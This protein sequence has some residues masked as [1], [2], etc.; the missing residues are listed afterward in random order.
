[1]KFDQKFSSPN[2]LD[3]I[4]SPPIVGQSAYALPPSLPA[5]SAPSITCTKIS[6]INANGAHRHAPACDFRG[7]H[8]NAPSAV[9][10]ASARMKNAIAR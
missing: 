1:V 7:G 4:H 10:S 6:V 2:A 9:Q 5:S 3:G 8:P